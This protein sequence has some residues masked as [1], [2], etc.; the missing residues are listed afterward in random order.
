MLQGAI[1][2][3]IYYVYAYLRK[4]G[5]PYY[6]GK[7]TARRA[8]ATH[9]TKINGVWV[10]PQ[11]PKDKSKI[12][13]VESNLTEMGAFALERR[14]I[15][16]YGRKDNGTGILYNKTDGGEGTSGRI[17]SDEQKRKHSKI[18]KGRKTGPQT[19]EHSKNI[20]LSKIGKKRPDVSALKLGKS[21]TL[22]HN[23]NIRKSLL[24]KK[25]SI[26]I[27][28]HC[29]KSGGVANMTR[30]HFNNCRKR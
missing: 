1:S 12:I 2:M 10:G 17:C 4:T 27:C 21:N 16:W 25:H 19:P 7:G 11:T 24:G 8:W 28:P 29:E 18:M 23:N 22:T 14:M 9:R 26:V 30:Y 15:R 13:I 6:I 20:S 5:T 3:T